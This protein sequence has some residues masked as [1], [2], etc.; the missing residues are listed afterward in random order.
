[1]SLPYSS[2]RGPERSFCWPGGP[3]GSK[4][5]GHAKPDGPSREQRGRTRAVKSRAARVTRRRQPG[6]TRG[7]AVAGRQLS[8][9]PSDA[10]PTARRLPRS[11]A[12]VTGRCGARR[13]Q[14]PRPPAPRPGRHPRAECAG[15]REGVTAT[16]PEH[17]ALSGPGPKRAR[18]TSA[19][20]PGV[21]AIGEQERTSWH[22][23]ACP[24]CRVQCEL[25]KSQIFQAGSSGSTQQL[26]S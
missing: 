17:R 3:G 14:L 24:A 23:R 15:S 2:R 18:R 26:C 1:V 11:A 9:R 21:P 12:P 8:P 19:R 16:G 22:G 7:L 20:R 6:F 4:S 25:W 10:S 13:I 5:C